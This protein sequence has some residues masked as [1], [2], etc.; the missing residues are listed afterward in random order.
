MEYVM[1]H[2]AT[3]L[4]RQGHRVTV[5]AERLRWQPLGINLEYRVIRYGPAVRGARRLGIDFLCALLAVWRAHRREP[6]DVIHCHGVSYAGDRAAAL[7]RWLKVP[8][9][10]TPHGM[11]IQRIP[12]IGYGLRLDPGWDRRIRRNLDAADA[13]TA[14]SQS[15]LGELA[16]LAPGK[17]HLIPNGIF[18]NMYGRRE[19]IFLRVRLGLGSGTAII[20]SVGRNH[21]KKGYA[22]GIR[23]MRHL[24]DDYGF[25]DFR[26]VLVGRDMSSLEPVIAETGLLDK[27]TLIEEIPSDE[28]RD[29]YHSATI[30]FSPSIVEG[31]SLVSIEA[32]ACGLPLVATDVPGNE[33]IVRDNECGLIVKNRNPHDMARGLY[34]LLNNPDLR[35]SFA[36]KALHGSR[37][38]DW[39]EV[40]NQYTIVYSRV[41]DESK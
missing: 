31:L 21:V 12:E 15:V 39:N 1:H 20:L 17:V 4:H 25:E 23:A 38:Y 29:C 33:D 27:V 26:Y 14:I 37:N 18:T 34:Q 19:S 7:R 8:V 11:D 5:I 2:L 36:Q 22:D 3:T 30:F 28:V 32:I 35:E 41:L 9:V 24:I 40:A 13:V 6:F 16:D 10:M